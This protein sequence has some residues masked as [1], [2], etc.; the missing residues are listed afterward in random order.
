MLIIMKRKDQFNKF[1]ALRS[2]FVL[3]IDEDQVYRCVIY[4][5]KKFKL[6]DKLD[7]VQIISEGKEKK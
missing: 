5:D 3:C 1:I 6:F 2:K 7:D 4:H